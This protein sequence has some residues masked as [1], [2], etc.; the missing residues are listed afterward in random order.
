M[1]F[2]RGFKLMYA[3]FKEVNYFEDLISQEFEKVKFSEGIT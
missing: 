3:L 2:W 1:K